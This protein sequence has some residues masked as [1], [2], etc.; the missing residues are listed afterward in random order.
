MTECFSAA[1]FKKVKMKKTIKKIQK[2]KD[3]IICIERGN[4]QGYTFGEIRQYIRNKKGTYEP[5]QKGF[6][7]SPVI[8]KDLIDGLK[9]LKKSFS[10]DNLL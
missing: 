5:S 1:L 7:F 9:D 8:L 10:E 2:R 4:M 3:V 6:T